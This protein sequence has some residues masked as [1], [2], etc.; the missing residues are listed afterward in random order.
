MCGS[1]ESANTRLDVTPMLANANSSAASTQSPCWMKN[2][3]AVATTPSPTQAPSIFFLMPAKSA[4]AP[5]TGAS[6]ATK[7]SASVVV[8]ANRKLAVAGSRSAAATD[9]K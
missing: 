8:T 6:T 9:E 4:S 7:L 1:S 3:H 5:S 2:M